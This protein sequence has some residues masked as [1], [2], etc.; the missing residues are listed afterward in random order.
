MVMGVVDGQSGVSR[1]QDPG[2]R[3]ESSHPR[4]LVTRVGPD[5][6][7]GLA[8]AFAAAGCRVVLDP[9]PDARLPSES[10]TDAAIAIRS[11][12]RAA[13]FFGGIDVCV[14]LIRLPRELPSRASSADDCEDLLVSLLRAPFHSADVLAGRMRLTRNEGLI[15]NVVIE[16]AASVPG[17]APLARAAIAAMTRLEAERWAAHGIRVNSIGPVEVNAASNREDE[18][19]KIARL[20]L[21]LARGYAGALSGVVLDPA[22]VSDACC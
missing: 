12:Q 1:D 4:I 21:E 2:A 15:L 9:C 11:A 22:L 19:N 17:L 18:E 6:G 8:R 10:G 20:T 3:A 14:N 16:P 5:F 13:E 7:L